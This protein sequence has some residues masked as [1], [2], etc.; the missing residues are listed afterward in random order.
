MWRFLSRLSDPSRRLGFGLTVAV[1]AIVLASLAVKSSPATAFG[2]YSRGNA[3]TYADSWSSNSANF[4]NPDYPEFCPDCT[5]FVSQ[6]LWAGG[7]PSHGS[8]DASCDPNSWWKPYSF[9]GVWHYPHAWSESECQREFFSAQWQDFSLYGGSPADLQGGDILQMGEF[10]STPTHAR[11]LIGAGYDETTG[12]WYPNL[13][14]QHTTDRHHVRWDYG[15]D[16]SW[17][18]WAWQVNW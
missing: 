3:I 13:H 4:R 10:S 1:V 18:L 5:N 16:P 6:V 9:L 15:I 11:V 2:S 17:P 7:Y 12:I 8:A 14:D